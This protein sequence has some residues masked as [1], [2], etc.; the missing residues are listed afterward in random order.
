MMVPD[1]RSL[2]PVLDLQQCRFRYA[3]TG[4]WVLDGVDLTIHPGE[5][6][7]LVGPNGGGKTTL[8]KLLHGLLRPLA[9]TV[10]LLGHTPKWSRHEPELGYIGHPSRNDG[11]SGLPLDLRIGLLLDT[12]D[13][14]HAAAG[15]LHP[16]AA[17]LQRELGL[18]VLRDRR[19][20]ALSDGERL[21]V[22]A[23]LALA[24]QPR[25]LVADE[26]TSNLDPEVRRLLLHLVAERTGPGKAAL[27][28]VS[29]RYEELT[30]LGVDSICRLASGQLS[31]PAVD[32]WRCRFR[33]D[34]EH[35]EFHYLPPG[36]LLEMLARHL[37][38]DPPET[39]ELHGERG[40][41]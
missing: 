19:G 31:R 2:D 17:G 8:I 32:G 37:A 18:A 34:E 36:E 9:G 26:A 21:R 40:H 5:R 35:R 38:E 7:G 10:S 39:F 24:K 3:A 20:S 12:F 41:A 33:C 28:W 1:S 16:D 30:R 14:L 11:E 4:D 29:H 6:V 25:L 27:L 13:G 15:R 22:Q 23:Y